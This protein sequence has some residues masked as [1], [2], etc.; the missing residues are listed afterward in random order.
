MP[1]N[2]KEFVMSISHDQAPDTDTRRNP[3]HNNFCL[4]QSLINTSHCG[5]TKL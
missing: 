5:K 4:L 1:K 3:A 2:A